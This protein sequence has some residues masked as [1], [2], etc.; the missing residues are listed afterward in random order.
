MSPEK[1]ARELSPLGSRISTFAESVALRGAGSVQFL[2]VKGGGK[3][4]EFSFDENGAVWVEYWLDSS[5]EQASPVREASFEGPD[6]GIESGDAV[7]I[8]IGDGKYAFVRIFR[9]AGKSFGLLFQRGNLPRIATGCS[10]DR[11]SNVSCTRRSAE[12]RRCCIVERGR[13]NSSRWSRQGK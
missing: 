3:S 2:Y 7:S 13:R 11:R 5:D 8:P 12:R 4:V 6:E 9:D 1:I 10:R